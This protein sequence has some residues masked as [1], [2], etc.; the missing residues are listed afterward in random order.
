MS[1]SQ[2]LTVTAAPGRIVPIHPSIKSG[3]GGKLLRIKPGEVVELPNNVTVRRRI[4]SGD[5]VIVS[6]AD[7]K[8]ATPSKE[9]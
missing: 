2:T 6:K 1:K 5:L 7:A 3:L 8:K 4:H 9:S